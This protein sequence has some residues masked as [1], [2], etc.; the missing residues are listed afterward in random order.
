MAG[1]AALSAATLA[2]SGCGLFVGI[3][4]L[5]G[6]ADG[7][8][9]DPDD[10]GTVDGGPADAGPIDGGADAGPCGDCG[11]DFCVT[12]APVPYCTS[13]CAVGFIHTGPSYEIDET[14]RCP[15]GA[16]CVFAQG[17]WLCRPDLDYTCADAVA[18]CIG[19]DLLFLGCVDGGAAVAECP[20]PEPNCPVSQCFHQDPPVGWTCG[21]AYYGALD[22]CDCGCGIPDP[23]CPSL[24]AED[25]DWCTG[26]VTDGG[27]TGCECRWHNG[28]CDL[29][30]EPADNTACLR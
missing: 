21:G 16:P 29:P 27:G 15:A 6:D 10:G 26:C 7:G 13:E 12:T 28:D 23:D 25:C 17:R 20:A 22:G 4:E 8:D 11:T 9:P 19:E 30:I 14:G 2:S 1:L 3:I 24:A 5:L 18:G